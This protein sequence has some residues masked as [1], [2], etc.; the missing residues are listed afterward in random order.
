M[1][2]K[3]VKM[4]A[5]AVVN[6]KAVKLDAEEFQKMIGDMRAADGQEGA[7]EAAGAAD[8]FKKLFQHQPGIHAIDLEKLR[9]KD[10]KTGKKKT[11]EEEIEENEKRIDEAIWALKNMGNDRGEV[12]AA[13]GKKG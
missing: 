9:K 11:K 8:L 5:Y 3:E 1:G 12:G 13:G 10:D 4:D 7:Q 2:P 6:G